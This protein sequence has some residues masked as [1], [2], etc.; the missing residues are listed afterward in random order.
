LA[1]GGG[2]WHCGVCTTFFTYIIHGFISQ[3]GNDPFEVVIG[4]CFVGLCLYCLVYIGVIST[5]EKTEICFKCPELFKLTANALG[6]VFDRSNR[7]RGCDCATQICHD[8]Q[9]K[10]RTHSSSHSTQQS[11]AQVR[12]KAA[13]TPASQRHT[14]T[15]DSS[16]DTNIKTRH[17]LPLNFHPSEQPNI[18][19]EVQAIAARSYPLFCLC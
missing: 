6:F 12:S 3:C 16:S 2:G 10:A 7:D 5:R 19:L 11:L 14:H 13:A 9:Q 4:R 18:Q 15:S 8:K 17:S 1:G